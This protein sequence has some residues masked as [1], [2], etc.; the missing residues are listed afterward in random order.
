MS[1]PLAAALLLLCAFLTG[2]T[3]VDMS[4]VR[5]IAVDEGSALAAVNAFR[6]RNGLEPLGLDRRLS[7]AAATQSAAMAARDQ[8]GHNVDGRL[9]GRVQ[10]VGYDWEALAEN[11][12][13]GYPSYAAAMQGWID[14]PDHRRN[15][16]NPRVTHLGVA[17]A[18]GGPED[19]PYWT[20]I[21]AAERQRQPVRTAGETPRFGAPFPVR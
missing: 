15:L 10:A 5:P 6:T 19:R 7:Q 8:M 1:Q 3:T 18:R 11:L 2:C 17:A 4:S 16:L 13:R 20:Q 9:P 21:F 12:G 14:S